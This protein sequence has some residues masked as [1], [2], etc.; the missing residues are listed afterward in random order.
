[1]CLIKTMPPW[2][3]KRYHSSKNPAEA[4]TGIMNA[5]KSTCPWEILEALR[6]SQSA[7]CGFPLIL[8]K[9]RIH[10]RC[11]HEVIISILIDSNQAYCIGSSLNQCNMIG[12]HCPLVKIEQQSSLILKGSSI[13]VDTGTARSTNSTSAQTLQNP[14]ERIW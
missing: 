1:M 13:P 7:K 4:V 6:P 5:H 12:K 9:S 8:F 3:Q 2:K 10:K 14:L 11:I